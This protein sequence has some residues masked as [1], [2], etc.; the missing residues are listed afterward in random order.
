MQQELSTGL[1]RAHGAAAWG[2]PRAS[3]E[4]SWPWLCFCITN[5]Y[6]KQRANAEI[7]SEKCCLPHSTW[8]KPSCGAGP[9]PCSARP[10]PRQPDLCQRLWALLCPGLRCLARD[11]RV[12]LR[13]MLCSSGPCYMAQDHAVL[14]GTTLQSAGPHC[15]LLHSGWLLGRRSWYRALRATRQGST[16][17]LNPLPARLLLLQKLPLILS[18]GALFGL[19]V[20]GQLVRALTSLAGRSDGAAVRKGGPNSLGG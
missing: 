4:Q 1:D 3:P 20:P 16:M 18:P 15:V 17:G 14:L 19:R 6:R 2:A 9:A 8:V 13:V 10:C 12:V 11:H 7:V 5:I